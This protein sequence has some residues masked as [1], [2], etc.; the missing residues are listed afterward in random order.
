[1][2]SISVK[3]Q[4]EIALCRLQKKAL[5]LLRRFF[6]R[7]DS[8]RVIH[9]FCRRHFQSIADIY[10]DK[11]FLEREQTAESECAAIWV[12]WWQ[13]YDG[14][15]P[16]VRRCIDSIRLHAGGHPVVLLTR[17]NCRTYATLP[18][19]VFEKVM[20][21]RISLTHLSDILRM[22]LLA[23]HGG[24]WLDAT[25]FVSQDIPEVYFQMPLFTVRYPTSPSTITKG[26]WTGF[27]QAAKQGCLLH[28]YCLDVFLAYWRTYNSLIDYFFID[29][30]IAQAYEQIPSVREAIDSIPENNTGIKL[31]DRLFF[32]PYRADE[33]E[34]VLCDS[35]F[36][37]LNRKR[38]YP[39]KDG[40]GMTTHYGHFMR[41][42]ESDPD[43]AAE[44]PLVSVVIP[45]YNRAGT[46][47]RSVE[48]VLGQSYRNIE[49]IVVDDCSADGTEEIL[50][51]ITDPRLRV[52]RHEKNKGQNAARNTGTIAATGELLAC[53]DSDDVWHADKLEKQ[54]AFMRRTGADIVCAMTAVHNESDNSFMY[55]HPDLKKV[56]EGK[57][58][59]EN[60]LKY[61]CTTTQ[62]F[63]GKAECFK[64]ILFDENQP[65][66]TDW[67]LA[68]DMVR[69]YALYLQAEVLADVFQQKDSITRNPARGIAGMDMLYQKHRAAIDSDSSIQAAFFLKKAGSVW[70]AGNS[71]VEELRIVYRCEPNTKNLLKLIL[72]KLRLYGIAGKLLGK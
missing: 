50:S 49:L 16:L 14:A 37:K 22:S 3:A 70:R 47:L 2:E 10:R 27:C 11:P 60:L 54:L 1:M 28:R 33:Y 6:R 67:A 23:T 68:L 61:N 38:A 17:E 21:G 40:N 63:F 64:E 36:H 52:I 56:S 13:G 26:R 34:Q 25:I 41:G 9:R 66:F 35:V 44:R 57:V 18:E 39:E 58:I 55:F 19:Y 24:L 69:K 72:A 59:Y 53:H 8:D 32:R 12:F 71:P 48:S 15:P 30:V 65:R 43:S 51:K 7:I 4:A 46:I 31:L 45:T 62:T 5:S 29:Y 42:E 20:S